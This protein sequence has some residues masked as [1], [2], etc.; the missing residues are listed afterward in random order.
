MPDPILRERRSKLLKG[1]IEDNIF[2][3][4]T[5]EEL[6]SYFAD[7]NERAKLHKVLVDRG[8]YTKS[9]AEFNNQYFSD[10]ITE[11]TNEPQKKNF[12]DD[13]V[14]K[15]K[16]KPGTEESK[17]SSTESTTGGT[18]A[19][20]YRDAFKA[21]SNKYLTEDN[22]KP[23]TEIVDWTNPLSAEVSRQVQGLGSVYG[24]GDYTQEDLNKGAMLYPS[25]THYALA[26]DYNKGQEEKIKK[27]KEF[28]T[29]LTEVKNEYDQKIQDV[30]QLKES[31]AIDDKREK[32]MVSRLETQRVEAYKEVR[33]ADDYAMGLPQQDV[34]IAAQ[35]YFAKQDNDLKEV[36]KLN[37]HL[38]TM[39]EKDEEKK[40]NDKNSWQNIQNRAYER[41]KEKTDLYDAVTGGRYNQAYLENWVAEAE[42]AGMSKEE[43]AKGYNELKSE[44]D[45]YY[46][47]HE[48]T[49]TTWMVQQINTPSVGPNI[50][51]SIL[52]PTIRNRARFVQPYI[53]EV[54]K[55]HSDL[56]IEQKS[57]LRT[58]LYERANNQENVD[59]L[60][61]RINRA[62]EKLNLP[63]PEQ[64]LLENKELEEQ[65]K[66]MA[67][68]IGAAND[69]F[70]RDV[71]LYKAKFE[72][73]G[74][75]IN[76]EWETQSK[77]WQ[78][79]KIKELEERKKT[80]QAD[81][82]AGR[83]KP[84]DANKQLE[85]ILLASNQE[86]QDLYKIFNTR[87][88]KLL[89]MAVNDEQN[90]KSRAN[91]LQKQMKDL[92][93]FT[94]VSDED[95]KKRYGMTKAEY[96]SK[97]KTIA[98]AFMDEME[99]YDKKIKKMR[100]DRMGLAEQ[101]LSSTYNGTSNLQDA[102]FGSI[103]YFAPSFQ[104]PDYGLAASNS[105]RANIPAPDLGEFDIQ[106]LLKPDFYIKN[107][108]EMAPLMIP[109]AG[110]GGAV[111]RGT[112]GLL[113]RTGLSMTTR[114]TIASVFGAASSRVIEAHME[115]AGTM[116]EALANGETYEEALRQFN[117]VRNGNLSLIA[118]DALQ[119]YDIF[120]KAGKI[121]AAGSTNKTL[122]VFKTIAGYGGKG[123]LQV[124][125]GAAEEL[126]QEY[127]NATATDPYISFQ[128]F[129]MS[130]AGQEIMAVGGVMELAFSVGM[131]GFA[132]RTALG[133]INK[134]VKRYF[135]DFDA[136]NV[137][138]ES[139]K[140]RLDQ[141]IKTIDTLEAQGVIS[142]EEIADARQLMK[143]AYSMFME[144][145]NGELPFDFKSKQFDR[146]SALQYERKKILAQSDRL[147]SKSDERYKLLNKV[148][149][150]DAEIE[151]LKNDAEVYSFSFNGTPLSRSEFESLALNPE[152]AEA[153]KRGDLETDDIKLLEKI[154]QKHTQERKKIEAVGVDAV[155]QY[156]TE[157]L[158]L[159][160][161]GTE[162]R[163]LTES[164]NSLTP[165][166]LEK[167]KASLE[168]KLKDA[169]AK[170]E[171]V[172]A[173]GNL[174]QA[175]QNKRD[176]EKQLLGL[177]MVIENQVKD[178]EADRIA[179]EKAMAGKTVRTQAEL[180]AEI[181]K[182]KSQRND[183]LDSRRD[184]LDN[185]VVVDIQSQIEELQKQKQ[186]ELDKLP[187]GGI[188]T[189]GGLNES[190]INRKNE[191]ESALAETKKKED[192]TG[193][194]SNY[195]RVD[196]KVML[197]S[198]AQ[199]EL[200][201]L[202]EKG[203]SAVVTQSAEAD[204]IEKEYEQKIKD[205]EQTDVLDAEER[206]RKQY[207]E[208]GLSE[209]EK[210]GTDG[211][212]GPEGYLDKV[213]AQEELD[214]LNKVENL[215]NKE[216]AA[217]NKNKGKTVMDEIVERYDQQIE[218][219]KAKTYVQ[220]KKAPAAEKTTSQDAQIQKLKSQ[221]NDELDSKR[222]QLDDLLPDGSG[223]TVMD[224]I[225]DRYD[226]MIDEVKGK[227]TEAKVSPI[228]P[229][230][231]LTPKQQA[232]IQKIRDERNAELE[233]KKDY[234]DDTYSV[235]S[236]KT[237][238]EEI[239]ERYDK[240][241][242]D[243]KAGLG[244]TGF[245]AVGRPGG[246]KPETKQE[247]KSES[248]QEGLQPAGKTEA[249]TFEQRKAE[250][251]KITDLEQRKVAEIEFIMS[252]LAS[253]VG[254]AAANKIKE[255]ADRIISGKETREQVIQGLSK[256][257]V[258]G[259]DQLLAAEQSA[260]IDNPALANVEATAA[261]LKGKDIT[262]ILK[263]ET[264]NELNKKLH[265][266]LQIRTKELLDSGWEDLRDF[267]EDKKY[268]EIYRKIQVTEAII[269]ND[270]QAIAIEYHR[271]KG[272][273]MKSTLISAVETLL[274]EPKTEQ[275]AISEQATSKVPVQSET[276]TGEKVEEGKSKT[277]SKG[278]TEEGK[279]DERKKAIVRRT[280]STVSGT[281]QNGF[282]VFKSGSNDPM[283]DLDP[284]GLKTKGNENVEITGPDAKTKLIGRFE[285]VTEG[286]K[287]AIYAIAQQ[288]QFEG[289]E[290][291]TP[292]RDKV[293]RTGSV[294]VSM[295]FDAADGITIEDA[296]QELLS[297]LTDAVEKSVDKNTGKI[298]KDADFNVAGEKQEM[299]DAF[300]L[301][302]NEGL[303]KATTK[304]YKGR[305]IG[306]WVYAYLDKK[307]QKEYDK[308][309]DAANNYGTKKQAEE[310]LKKLK[311]FE[312]E[313]K[314]AFEQAKEAID[315]LKQKEEIQA[316]ESKKQ[317][318]IIDQTA[319]ELDKLS[320]K[321]FDKLVELI[322][323]KRRQTLEQRFGDRVERRT[324]FKTPISESYHKAKADGSNPKLVQAVED[325]LGTTEQ[326]QQTELPAK[327]KLKE[328]IKAGNKKNIGEDKLD[329]SDE[330]IESIID[331]HMKSDGTVSVA[332]LQRK[333]KIGFHK[334][335]RIAENINEAILA[336]S[337]PTTEQKQTSGFTAK[338]SKTQ[339][340]ANLLLEANAPTKFQPDDRLIFTSK[341][342]VETEVNFR[343]YVDDNTVVIVGR[344]KSGIDQMTVNVNQVKY[345][346][347]QKLNQN[348]QTDLDKAI[349]SAEDYLN[350]V[351]GEDR[352]IDAI[353]EVLADRQE[354][355]DRAVRNPKLSEQIAN[356]YIEAVKNNSN[357]EL[358]EAVESI[359]G[360]PVQGTNKRRL[361][362]AADKNPELT[363]ETTEKNTEID[364][365]KDIRRGY[366]VADGEKF[367]R[368][369]PIT[370]K[371]EGRD[372]NVYF[373]PKLKVPAKYVLLEA[374]EVQ[375]SHY[376]GKPNMHFFLSAAQPKPRG[377]GEYFAKTGQL[378]AM[379]LEPPLTIEGPIAYIGAPVVNERGELVQ[380]TGR[381]E[382]LKIAYNEYQQK[383]QEYKEYLIENAALFGLDPNAVKNMKAPILVRMI[384][385]TD[386]QAIVYG[387]YMDT[388]MIDVGGPQAQAISRIRKADKGKFKQAISVLLANA[389]PDETINQAIRS[390]GKK[391]IDL[392]I[393]A[394]VIS[395]QEALQ[396]IYDG[397]LSTELARALEDA[398]FQ[399]GLEGGHPTLMQEI[400]RLPQYAEDAIK[401][402]IVP[403][404]S[405]NFERSYQADMHMAIIG[406][407]EYY[408]AAEQM[409]GLRFDSWIQMQET[410]IAR[411]TPMKRYSPVQ[412][413]IMKLFID[414]ERL[415][416]ELKTPTKKHQA[417]L[418]VFTDYEK[419]VRTGMKEGEMSFLE[420]LGFEAPS[421]NEAFNLAFK[422]NNLNLK[423]EDYDTTTAIKGE[424][425]SGPDLFGTEGD[426]TGELP[427]TT[428]EGKTG[429]TEETRRGQGEAPP[430]DL[431]IVADE[432]G[433]FET[434]KG[435]QETIGADNAVDIFNEMIKNGVEPNIALT[436]IENSLANTGMHPDMVK[437]IYDMV[438]EE[439][440]K[441][442]A[443]KGIPPAQTEI[444]KKT[445]TAETEAELESAAEE[446]DN[447]VDETEIELT[448]D[449]AKD[450]YKKGL[451]SGD[452]YFYIQ[453][454][455]SGDT[456][457]VYAETFENAKKLI[458][459][460]KET[461]KT[462]KK[463]ETKK[464]SKPR[465]TSDKPKTERKAKNVK[466]KKVETDK[467]LKDALS[468]LDDL[469]KK[470][471]KG[472]EQKQTDVKVIDI[473]RAGVKVGYFA[474]E[475]FKETYA[476]N[477]DSIT[478]EE[479]DNFM[480]D[481]IGDRIK[482]YLNDIWNSKIPPSLDTTTPRFSEYTKSV[483]DKVR[484]EA[485]RKAPKTSA[486]GDQKVETKEAK[487][488]ETKPLEAKGFEADGKQA[489]PVEKK[490]EPGR[491]PPL[492]YHN[493]D[494]MPKNTEQF[495]PQEKY[496]ADLDE[497]QRYAVNLMLT[498]WFTNGKKAFLLNDSMGVG[499]TRQMIAAAV[500]VAERTGK[501]V[502]IVT[503][504][505]Q[506]IETAF[507]PDAL[508]MGVD[509]QAK[510]IKIITYNSLEKE[511]DGDYGL[512]IYD[513]AHN[514]KNYSGRYKASEKIK[515]DKVLYSTATP[516]DKVENSMYFMPEMMGM[517]KQEFMSEFGIII[518]EDGFA[519]N[520]RV[521]MTE[522]VKRLNDQMQKAYQE[523]MTIRREY[524]FWGTISND[525]MELTPEQVD[526]VDNVT[527]AW[528]T[529]IDR[530]KPGP[531]TDRRTGQ[532]MTSR[533][534]RDWD[535]RYIGLS[536][537]DKD[538]L[539]DKI[540]RELREQKINM[541]DKLVESYKAKA[542]AIRIK[543]DLANGKS[544]VVV[545]QNVNEIKIKGLDGNGFTMSEVVRP[546]F[547]MNLKAELAAAGIKFAEV[548]AK[549]DK[550][551]AVR[552]F[553]NGE[554]NVIIGSMD[555]MSTG[556]SLDDTVGS[557]PRVLYVAQ[558]S[559]DA[560]VF[561]QVMGRVSRRNTKSEAQAIVLYGNTPSE[562]TKEAKVTRKTGILG[563]FQGYGVD[564]A[565][566]TELDKMDEFEAVVEK[567]RE[568]KQK[569]RE[570]QKEGKKH[571]VKLEVVTVPGAGT[572]F[573]SVK[574]SYE[575]RDIL[576]DLGG[577]YSVT[578]KV[579]NFPIERK[580]ELEGLIEKFNNGTLTTDEI[581]KATHKHLSTTNP[582]PG[583]STGSS[584]LTP[585]GERVKVAPLYGMSPVKVAKIIRDARNKLK[586][587]MKYGY[588][589]S[590]RAAGSYHSINS[591]IMIRKVNDL[592]VIVH[593]LG[594][595][596]QDYK[597][598]TPKDDQYDAELSKFWPFGSPPPADASEAAAMTYMRGEGIAEFVRAYMLNPAEA[599][600]LAPEFYDFF[601]SAVGEQDL[602]N[603]Q[604]IGQ[605]IRGLSGLDSFQKAIASNQ[606]N[607]YDLSVVSTPM[608]N[609]ARWWDNRLVAW[610]FK[611]Y[612]MTAF[613]MSFSDKVKRALT[614]E[615]E[616][617]LKAQKQIMGIKGIQE[618][619]PSKNPYW[620]ARL[621][622]GIGDKIGQ[623][624]KNGLVR[625]GPNGYETATNTN[626]KTGKKEAITLS[627][628][629]EPFSTLEAGF[630]GFKKR[631]KEIV[632]AK[633]LVGSYMVAERT[634]E[635]SKRFAKEEVFNMYKITEADYALIKYTF[636]QIDQKT[637]DKNKNAE[638]KAQFLIDNGFRLNL[639]NIATIDKL[640]DWIK[641][642]YE[643][644]HPDISN[645]PLL[646]SIKQRVISG[647]GLLG[648][649]DFD[650]AKELLN[651]IKTELTPE[652]QEMLKE[653]AR[654]YRVYADQIL[655]Y[656][657]DHG[658][659]SPDF[660]KEIM[661]NNLQYV[662]MNRVMSSTPGFDTNFD[663]S[664]Q[665]SLYKTASGRQTFDDKI[666]GSARDR[667]DPYENL[668][669]NMYKAI[670]EADTN[671][672]LNQF[673]DLLR[674]NRG[675]EQGP[676]QATANIGRQIQMAPNQQIGERPAIVIYNNGV[677][678][679][680][681]FD[682]NVYE[683]LSTSFK[684]EKQNAL[685]NMA[686][687][688]LGAQA[689]VVR[690]TATKNAFFAARNIIRDLQQRLFI[691]RTAYKNFNVKQA[692]EKY[693][694]TEQEI[695]NILEIATLTRTDADK[696]LQLYGGGQA[697]YYTKSRE[698]YYA[699]LYREMRKYAAKG[700]GSIIVDFQ[701]LKNIYNNYDDWLAQGERVTRVSEYQSA[702]KYA[703][704]K[705]GYSEHD[706]AIYA[707]FQARDLM[708]FAKIGVIMKFVNRVIPFSNAQLQGQ[709]RMLQA[710][711]ENPA[712]AITS[713][714]AGSALPA[715]FFYAMAFLGGYEDEYMELPPHERDLFY[716]FK[717]PAVSDEMIR[718][719]KPF[720]YG[721]MG[722]SV[723]RF[724]QG[725]HNQDME[726]AFRG[727]VGSYG[728]AYSLFNPNKL[729]W[730]LTG[731]LKP[732]LEV[733][734]NYNTFYKSTIIPYKESKLTV[735]D[736]PKE[737]TGSYLGNIIGDALGGQDSRN[738]DHL[739]K[740]YFTF[741]GEVGIKTV[742]TLRPGEPDREDYDTEK[743]Y[744]A[745]MSKYVPGNDKNQFIS[746][747]S[748][749]SESLFDNAIDVMKISGFLR[750]S[751]K[752][753]TTAT[754]GIKEMANKYDLW[755]SPDYNDLEKAIEAFQSAQ[756]N[757]GRKEAYNEF[758]QRTEVIY[759]N[760]LE[761]TAEYEKFLNDG[762]IDLNGETIYLDK[763]SYVKRKLFNN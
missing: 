407:R 558:A 490:K 343:G 38:I 365:K 749:E 85:D 312:Q 378:K 734:T 322:D 35:K 623:M 712:Q 417:I 631:F 327:E 500:E 212:D 573:I 748:W 568:E 449:V 379:A 146:Y 399:L 12:L 175:I 174:V 184:E 591:A 115:A 677:R 250:I 493:Y 79:N 735:E 499:K 545:S 456:N 645:H 265:E 644:L 512:V 155:D 271:Q 135:N 420:D 471:G 625:L 444:E 605:S 133:Q 119:F 580:A 113:G 187:D 589:G 164:A 127:V 252:N 245:E 526:E 194:E 266:E 298:N 68:N 33:H 193:V 616:A 118:V 386:E 326:K 207:L 405:T 336:S 511:V 255:Y 504:N 205:L 196:G 515:T 439:Y 49:W 138:V 217:K 700:S 763:K 412:L 295:V 474:V 626:P 516:G 503:E 704:T 257:F 725:M 80:L 709:L 360:K 413:A 144:A 556:I 537:Y 283:G 163:L 75:D 714:M 323:E 278:T 43:I 104:F 473:I 584:T 198:E 609:L 395:R 517:T 657:M 209:M 542:V 692:L 736:R 109:G 642:D 293:E 372:T 635:L 134:Q 425:T 296:K 248:K 679:V 277:E 703:I 569:K 64:L 544:I 246:G 673:A 457:A 302:E 593:E 418:K 284:R 62:L 472:P 705:L 100:W 506:I 475:K 396:N 202:N 285:T 152:N 90:L 549:T 221:R 288:A 2:D 200:D 523:G 586:A 116:Q 165:E 698:H 66:K 716:N 423:I 173:G 21:L 730:D 505:K 678:E 350:D 575:M 435:R 619:R 319:Q 638:E 634:V 758:I 177:N 695:E 640:M 142:E 103:K 636:N 383:A 44:W 45:K 707:A 25:A 53:E 442:N 743:E 39:A 761:K 495:V 320:D 161:G 375:Q 570:E 740:G 597:K 197:K 612:D 683:A 427:F 86:Y 368:P 192:E 71:A 183:E 724:V 276:G 157:Q 501:P 540:Q 715:T 509:L 143:H 578:F 123:L 527:Y 521:S 357:S 628:L 577:K 347:N 89:E 84:A 581:N 229:T 720:E 728:N 446:F 132:D 738:I 448:A 7:G 318:K 531:Y 390:A 468:E 10:I 172:K 224:E 522:T 434:E 494:K 148:K 699:A 3:G 671:Y 331:N 409:K 664:T 491:R 272:L 36:Q 186:A 42:K 588:P 754:Q 337:K 693:G 492:R 484:Y 667:F 114:T 463:S 29:K 366:R 428:T 385:T 308:L 367:Y 381:T 199:E 160:T 429:R 65:A 729:I 508:A 58:Y 82:D 587:F 307:Q 181:Q 555:S 416:P 595:L 410:D 220:E 188:V 286:D 227:K 610:G 117:H 565:T 31:G 602:G 306:N 719:P 287:V 676:P 232:D 455:L 497:D 151:T 171:E 393:D 364:V 363:E 262:T 615:K 445:E 93:K 34:P 303:W 614:G 739:I 349:V 607:E 525:K 487:G 460:Y 528:D 681:E 216:A 502:L 141:L 639:D 1:L 376:K 122:D 652:K 30:K 234:L 15:P 718:I 498:N 225:V 601:E 579:W 145:Q 280:P 258:D 300:H 213:S 721:L 317:Q 54:L 742:E 392:L 328:A 106:D 305:D 733:A 218:E 479:W 507:G 756:E 263:P 608:E 96:E 351:L 377:A 662:A 759:K 477:P 102:I 538:L 4:E 40:R 469:F 461:L 727:H 436:N 131:G 282:S 292:F 744:K 279:K 520:G 5:V 633:Q 757:N 651:S 22:K 647:L 406:M 618:L 751:D 551:E 214:Q 73:L 63:T 566:Q 81:V 76:K 37:E 210:S 185:P 354:A 51:A 340:T 690:F 547:L 668:M 411:E 627:W 529:K 486:E 8:L 374:D 617:L 481:K 137:S 408:T 550:S 67:S 669:T 176:I 661:D 388:D 685:L 156:V 78:D 476:D 329:L 241:I 643:T 621:M 182:L 346:P 342:G 9:E 680:W 230:S 596:I 598:L 48:A 755:N 362:V 459:D 760:W 513:E 70:T 582:I 348:E 552:K 722:T 149:E 431:G 26:K 121:R 654:R 352:D 710:M 422:K 249:K 401:R 353:N 543:N 648:Q 242:E 311:D 238:M 380:G 691:S 572:Q 563:M 560:N 674:S 708:D 574:N 464:Q 397:K 267:R 370:D 697:G 450:M 269:N 94:G 656:M 660:V 261:A 655:Y 414:I 195:T 438:F 125:T 237:V 745:A 211:W 496:G 107:A 687:N 99:A 101:M 571:N 546:S 666:V 447:I 585:D 150:I 514:M 384:Q 111:T 653:S 291:F 324:L 189:E 124:T 50:R 441:L 583:T 451:I 28:D 534:Q 747:A 126:Y 432:K 437:T 243:Y 391:F 562:T 746:K 488:P 57:A 297:R 675:M 32:E 159:V 223:R 358:I 553:Q 259:I 524:P 18:N 247:P 485:E 576:K 178:A 344:P 382:G 359:I 105:L 74:N 702:Y 548:T 665:A 110:I 61:G 154:T 179:K 158:A 19:D 316:E 201:A 140:G 489:L 341:D 244:K 330:D 112:I 46:Q 398:I 672:M 684:G 190:E 23:T 443:Q 47:E 713:I 561:N 139:M 430:K 663:D 554:V 206:A 564:P 315:N 98:G 95:F 162:R 333:F 166:I 239:I 222:D 732:V 299:L 533:G 281:G 599:K 458:P 465:K 567:K 77:S 13:L 52:A 394:G 694:Y 453:E 510:G 632:N 402:I 355:I 641:S 590:P 741:F 260:K 108:G 440:K 483:Q 737:G 60:E 454:Y 603:I 613:K 361:F 203:Q 191:L 219:L 294:S 369:E 650:A 696:M 452:D 313:N 345:S 231:E 290:N 389:N 228:T 373:T 338:E 215:R 88:S 400:D 180:D 309:R 87:K 208:E 253:G 310:N 518:T 530:V 606:M 604:S 462:S 658:R 41:L 235:G 314:K 270:S 371:I 762:Y 11:T 167:T 750:K 72:K 622:P 339:R 670:E 289:D 170:I 204:K 335:S 482:P 706:A 236:N 387:N 226:K 723:E 120:K 275:D 686:L 426:A 97:Y 536:D 731:T 611:Q 620:L 419:S 688:I 711:R 519:R 637:F 594:H 415:N 304:S 689:K 753:N 27:N 256:S 649:N 55:E 14:I 424:G 592:D 147:D 254:E 321:D 233:D 717:I 129:A 153:L 470:L 629:A 480:I 466:E 268:D 334:A 332:G 20:Q 274:V 682:P 136:K 557:R 421:V 128:E 92:E 56:S 559:Y 6:E 752:D 535:K 532:Q 168:Q 630:K 83:I 478:R 433:G 301:V 59:I 325:V 624:Q 24:T 600:R 91:L 356:A 701:T 404:L 467:N 130:K 17:K 240:K 264:V 403:M 69:Q 541:L 539:D 726:K 251:E 659:L 646:N 273:G 16:Q 169:E